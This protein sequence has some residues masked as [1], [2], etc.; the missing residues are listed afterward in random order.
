MN[1]LSA[2]QLRGSLLLLLYWCF[3]FS[4]LAKFCVAAISMLQKHNTLRGQI[5]EFFDSNEYQ[6]R[7]S[8]YVIY[9][10][11]I[12]SIVTP[13]EFVS[14]GEERSRKRVQLKERSGK[15]MLALTSVQGLWFVRPAL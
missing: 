15:V 11:S 3:F 12:F 7:E 1:I 4:F 10:S 6:S 14:G 5:L 13:G 8:R 2:A 9:Y